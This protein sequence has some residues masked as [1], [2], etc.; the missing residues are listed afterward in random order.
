MEQ[1]AEEVKDILILDL[2]LELCIHDVSIDVVEKL[3]DV[4]LHK[5]SCL[6]IFLR[7]PADRA[8]DMLRTSALNRATTMSI[9]PAG[10]SR[11][12]NLHH[13]MSDDVIVD[14]RNINVPP[15]A[16]LLRTVRRKYHFMARR[17]RLPGTIQKL[18]DELFDI[19][20]GFLR[21]DPVIK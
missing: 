8:D 20:A 7:P 21:I 4:E 6:Q 16:F 12:G 5:I 2:L 1:L 11:H 19:G 14:R 17:L 13:H 15:F 10:K 3:P 18:R 9:H